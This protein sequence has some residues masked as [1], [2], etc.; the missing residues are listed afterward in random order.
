[1]EKNQKWLLK[2]FHGICG[3]LG[4]TP[5]DKL[6]AISGYGCE[7]SADMSDE[8][9]KDLCFKLEKQLDPALAEL[10]ACRKRVFA[11]IGSYLEFVGKESS[12]ELIKA[13]ACRA[14][15]Y[16]TFNRIPADRLRNIYH[17]FTKKHKDFERSW[18]Q[19]EELLCIKK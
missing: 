1:M 6:A 7:S 18:K 16:D 14:T 13:V 12:P 5:E 3:R 4:M 2:R 15:G 10:D 11:A 9:L 8:D 17:A 19:M